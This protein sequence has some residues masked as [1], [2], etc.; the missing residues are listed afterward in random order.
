MWFNGEILLSL[1]KEG[2]S[3]ISYNTPGV[4]LED[5]MLH[6]MSVMK[7]YTLHDSVYM[8]H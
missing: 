4:T 1:E 2:N 3:D 7:A 6:E 8:R 5:I